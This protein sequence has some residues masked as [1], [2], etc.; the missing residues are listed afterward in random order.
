M[1]RGSVAVIHAVTH[2]TILSLPS[3]V[4]HTACL[5]VGALSIARAFAIALQFA[6]VGTNEAWLAYTLTSAAIAATVRVVRAVS[7]ASFQTAIFSVV[8][9]RPLCISR[10][11]GVINWARA[12]AHAVDADSVMRTKFGA[13]LHV[14]CFACPWF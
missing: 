1:T 6:A 7:R 13:H 9:V 8:T 14:T 5:S 4:A 3:R 12:C 2:V 10:D 11:T